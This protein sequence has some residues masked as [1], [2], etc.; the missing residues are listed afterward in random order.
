MSPRGVLRSMEPGA[1]LPGSPQSVTRAL[2]RHKYL[3]MRHRVRMPPAAP[4]QMPLLYRRGR[5]MFRQV[6]V[7]SGW[8]QRGDATV[9]LW[10]IIG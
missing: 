3:S 1:K 8:R 5:L 2:H 10:P 9:N 4:L 6:S 7:C